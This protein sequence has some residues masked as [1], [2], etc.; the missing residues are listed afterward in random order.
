[1]GPIPDCAAIPASGRVE[2]PPTEAGMMNNATADASFDRSYREIGPTLRRQADRLRCCYD[3]ARQRDPKLEGR[4]LVSISLD[5]GGAVKSVSH[6]PERSDIQD[7][8]MGACVVA[9]VREMTFVASKR[10]LETAIQF[11]L[12]FRP[13]ASARLGPLRAKVGRGQARNDVR[14]DTAMATP[15]DTVRFFAATD[16]GRVRGHN[17][18]NFLIDRRLGLF[19][20]ADGMGGHAA[21]EVASALAVRTIHE[22]IKRNKPML[23]S[24]ERGEQGREAPTVSP[25]RLLAL[26]E[27][28]LQR[29]SARIH[30]A[31]QS[32][33]SKRGMGTTCVAL[34]LVGKRAFLAHA[35][36]SRIYL[37]HRQQVSQVTEDHTVYNEMIK[38]G[39]LTR[40]QIDKMTQKNAI[41]RALGIYEHVEVDSLMIE[42]SPG[43]TFL[44]CSDGLH[45]YL[46]SDEE[47]VGPLGASDDSGVRSL[48][49]LANARGGKDNITAIVLRMGAVAGD[50]ARVQRLAQKRAVL[51]RQ[52]LLGRLTEREL[53]RVM[54]IAR[55]RQLAPGETLVREGEAGDELF[56]VITGQ[57]RVQAGGH[58]V[59]TLGPGEH[60]GEL[61]LLRNLP[62]PATVTSEGA[63]HIAGIKRS[64]FFEVLRKEHE[65][66][67]KLLWQFLGV[68]A[69]RLDQTSRDLRL[70]REEHGVVE[71]V[72]TDIEIGTGEERPTLPDVE[73]V[74]TMAEGLRG[75]LPDEELAHSSWLTRATRRPTRAHA[76]G[77]RR[78]PSTA[79]AGSRPA[80]RSALP[81]SPARSSAP[82]G[83]ARRPP[84]RRPSPRGTADPARAASTPRAP[85]AGWSRS[86][87]PPRPARGWP[88]RR[89]SRPTPACPRA[90]PS[91]RCPRAG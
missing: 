7:E 86:P 80:Q 65:L 45:G 29:A 55:S 59:S 78:S 14:P 5:A 85:D 73:P 61:A 46:H 91:R 33:R 27:V 66:A 44:L 43:D 16:V 90:A 26:V 19:V 6:V 21:G 18:D 50:E 32:D 24:F 37:M 4:L 34:L 89:G 83:S 42:T 17:E 56:I 75:L 35:G 38:R 12:V 15:Q 25:R 71:P 49:D 53:L 58:E 8:A 13:V 67:V 57:L 30:E 20:V 40:E 72:F 63:T 88:S 84:A 52:P 11:P 31:A 48:I 3:A 81:G 39:R 9:T 22:E 77:C 51:S 62:R 79:A 70:A 2:F 54:Q 64:D 36:D 47:L 82:A 1:V 60:F 69:D 87:R 76:R 41:S 74:G 10:G 28:A 68:L 23:D